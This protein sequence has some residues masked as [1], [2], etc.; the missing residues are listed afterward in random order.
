MSSKTE[1]ARSSGFCFSEIWI[2]GPIPGAIATAIA[3]VGV[4]AAAAAVRQTIK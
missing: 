3:D 2:S 1:E 4:A